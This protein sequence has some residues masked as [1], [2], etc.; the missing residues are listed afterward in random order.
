MARISQEHDKLIKRLNVRI[1][2]IHKEFR[3]L[4]KEE[5]I[6]EQR[7]ESAIKLLLGDNYKIGKNGAIQ[8]NRNAEIENVKGLDSK[9]ERLLNMDTLGD[10]NR[11]SKQS[12]IEEGEKPTREKIKERSRERQRIEDF[13]EKNNDKIYALARAVNEALSNPD[14]LSDEDMTVYSNFLA[15]YDT[16][17]DR[18]S[19]AGRLGYSVLSTI[20]DDYYAAESKIRDYFAG[21]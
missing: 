12:L 16:Y 7:Y 6:L 15:S 1:A 10:F 18:P 4:P 20:M 5:R 19:G 2:D 3:D 11:K 17:T 14:E 21:L 13:F 8:I 9:L